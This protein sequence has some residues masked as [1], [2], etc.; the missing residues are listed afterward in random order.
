MK[1]SKGI[2][3]FIATL[4]LMVLAVSAG[5][6]IYAYTMGYLGGFGGTEQLGAM[7]ID[8]S[9]ATDATG[10]DT[11]TAYVR[12]IGKTTI[13][14]RKS[15]GAQVYIDGTAVTTNWTDTSTDSLVIGEGDVSELVI[16]PESATIDIVAGSTYEVKIIAA[17]NTQV[18]FSV[19]A[20]APSA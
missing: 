12:N 17:D 13:D 3:T 5:V 4:L 14:L 1:S 15:E 9:S 16:E 6:V 8:D 7:S 19:K 2:S 10:D 20:K 18:S 11:V